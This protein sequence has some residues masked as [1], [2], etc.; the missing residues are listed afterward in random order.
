MATRTG[1]TSL[2]RP[3]TLDVGPLKGQLLKWVGNKQ[4]VAAEIV[5]HFPARFGTYREPFLG[6]GA[7]LATLAPVSGVGSD[8]FSPLMDIWRALKDRPQVLKGWYQERWNAVVDAPDRVEGY[9]LKALQEA[10]VAFRQA[11]KAA[12]TR[13][14]MAARTTSIAMGSPIPA[15]WL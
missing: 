14:S 11:P 6:T 15:A 2:S 4:R 8:C 9:E 10:K 3:T 1:Q 7:V 12:L 5:S 13:L